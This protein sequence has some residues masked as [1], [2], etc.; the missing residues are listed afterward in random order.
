MLRSSQ[1]IAAHKKV[2]KNKIDASRKILDFDYGP[3]YVIADICFNAP[4]DK[5]SYR[6]CP[7]KD[8]RQDA[9]KLGNFAGWLGE[10]RRRYKID[11]GS[12]CHGVTSVDTNGNSFQMKRSGTISFECGDSH[13]ILSVTENQPCVYEVQMQT[14]LV[15]DDDE[16]K[17]TTKDLEDF[18]LAVDDSK[19]TG[20]KGIEEMIEEAKNLIVS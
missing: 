4:I 11:N 13:S 1:A 5:Y 7:L 6:V 10:E 18:I 3:L 19:I 12:V 20:G 2:I 16:L 14:F 17:T 9:T 8:V 15:C